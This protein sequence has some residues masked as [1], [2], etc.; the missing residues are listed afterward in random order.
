M[1][2]VDAV[3][4]IVLDEAADGALDTQ[5][6][7]VDERLRLCNEPGAL[8]RSLTAALERAAAWFW[9]LG[10]AFVPGPTA[11]ERLLAP[12]DAPG[13]PAPALLTSRLDRP[14]GRLFEP[15]APWPRLTEKDVAVTASEHRL[16]S[17]RAARWGSLLV[18]RRAVEA[19]APPRARYERWGDDIEWT[20]RLLKDEPGY[21]VPRSVAVRRSDFD[22]GRRTRR[23]S[24]LHQLGL[25]ADMLVRGPWSGEERAWSGV[26]LARELASQL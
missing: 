23:P 7:P 24:R 5:T 22:C 4:A 8:H 25:A 21:L 13:L 17:I 16:M 12:L 11:L 1:P 2:R 3:C 14:D 10:P 19:H 20:A 15:A 9:L 6:R 18:H 26:V